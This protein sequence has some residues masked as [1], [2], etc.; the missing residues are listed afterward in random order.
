MPTTVKRQV[1]SMDIHQQESPALRVASTCVC[2]RVAQQDEM[3]LPSG[4]QVQK[5]LSPQ[6][7]CRQ[8]HYETHCWEPPIVETHPTTQLLLLQLGFSNS[9]TTPPPAPIPTNPPV[10]HPMGSLQSSNSILFGPFQRV[11]VQFGPFRVASGESWYWVG[12][13]WGWG[14]LGSL[15]GG[16]P[17]TERKKMHHFPPLPHF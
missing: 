9:L 7:H 1:Q 11:S 4:L 5:A 8:N 6:H 17:L 12:S 10:P 16:N 13:G 14:G 3:F 15:Q 2:A